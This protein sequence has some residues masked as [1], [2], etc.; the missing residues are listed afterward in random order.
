MIFFSAIPGCLSI[1][2]IFARHAWDFG[3]GV[4]AGVLI[5]AAFNGLA[6]SRSIAFESRH[7]S[8]GA[9]FWVEREALVRPR[10]FYGSVVAAALFLCG[11]VLAV[12]IGAHFAAGMCLPLAFTSTAFV[13]LLWGKVP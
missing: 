1:L 12:S 10:F 9:D 4:W 8:E 7:L 6:W 3:A 5:A 2:G 11:L 13:M